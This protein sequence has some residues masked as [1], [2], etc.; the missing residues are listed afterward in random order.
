MD[1]Y[2]KVIGRPGQNFDDRTLRD[3]WGVEAHDDM[4]SVRSTTELE[5]EMN[6]MP[7]QQSDLF[8]FGTVPLK[9]EY[10]TSISPEVSQ[11]PP[12]GSLGLTGQESATDR[13]T[14]PEGSITDAA[15]NLI[16]AMTKMV[17]NRGRKS[18]RA[19]DEG[20]DLD[21]DAQLSQPQRQMLQK[22]LSVALERL[23][24]ENESTRD[25]SDKQGWFQCDACPKQT[26]L[27]CEMK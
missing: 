18:T 15:D 1:W 4:A 25:T 27:R 9:P 8:K 16:N 6:T 13:N 10:G 12:F 2:E 21:S 22:V 23:S 14:K 5:P 7:Q 17:N 24:D 20:I 19:F 11:Y 3:E 26:R